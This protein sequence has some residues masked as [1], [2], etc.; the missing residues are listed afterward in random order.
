LS[1]TMEQIG[2]EGKVTLKKL[3]SAEKSLTG[4]FE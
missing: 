4:Q 1:G 3:D 2:Q